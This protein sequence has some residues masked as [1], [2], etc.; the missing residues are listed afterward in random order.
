MPKVELLEA[1][2]GWSSIGIEKRK[3]KRQLA[4]R[5]KLVSKRKKCGKCGTTLQ[6]DFTPSQDNRCKSCRSSEKDKL[7]YSELDDVGVKWARVKWN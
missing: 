3:K 7:T 4:K 1:S 5:K 2:L 6:E